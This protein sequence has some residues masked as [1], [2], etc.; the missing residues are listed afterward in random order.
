MIATPQDTFLTLDEA[1]E[2]LG[3]HPV[4]LRTH[5]ARHRLGVKFGK[6]WRF[7]ASSCIAF[8][9][10]EIETKWQRESLVS[11]SVP[12]ARRG[13]QTYGS[14]ANDL[15]AAL[16]SLRAERKHEKQQTRRRQQPTKPSP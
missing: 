6:E 5:P 11:T 16:A 15:G 7:L 13:T 8:I 10:E 1:A 4:T 12:A 9:Q 14:A 3:M 2:A